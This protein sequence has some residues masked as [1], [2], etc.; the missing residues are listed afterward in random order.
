MDRK[1]EEGRFDVVWPLARKAQGARSTAKAVS[2]LSGKTIAEV[3]DYIFRGDLIYPI[4]RDLLRERYPGIKFVDYT[5]FGNTHGPKQREIVAGLSQ[6][7]RDLRCDA[8]I[9]GIGA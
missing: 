7:L 1:L 3:W 9:S 2:D 6:K 4:I 8:V 5:H